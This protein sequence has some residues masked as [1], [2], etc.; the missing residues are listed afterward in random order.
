[1]SRLFEARHMN[2]W[3][4]KADYEAGFGDARGPDLRPKA[5][6]IQLARRRT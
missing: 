2:T 6:V 5:E 1:M 4:G 3:G